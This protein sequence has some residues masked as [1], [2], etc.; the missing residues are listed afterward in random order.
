MNR[1]LPLA[2]LL[3]WSCAPKAEN[4]EEQAVEDKGPKL[5]GRIA[6]VPADKRFV[7]I[8]SYGRW[9]IQAGAIL[10][11]RG[12][13]ERTANLK[14]TGESL[15]QFAAADVQSGTVQI[16][17]AVYSQHIPKPVETADPS[18]QATSAETQPPDNQPEMPD[19]PEF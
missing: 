9:N 19:L 4:T 11:T 15:G 12:T 2:A 1:L 6:T 17:D 14:V 8:Q 10:T 13:N 18:Q 5:V 16:G 3:I 7:L